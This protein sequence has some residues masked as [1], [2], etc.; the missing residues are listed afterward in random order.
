MQELEVWEIR[1]G[2]L[3]GCIFTILECSK[4]S[5]QQ[6]KFFRRSKLHP[7][8]GKLTNDVFLLYAAFH[9]FLGQEE[10]STISA[11]I[12]YFNMGE[13]RSYLFRR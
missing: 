7:Y 3:S 9:K 11:S 13:V 12:Y 10:R 5:F 2:N 8:M 4:I 6:N 1:G